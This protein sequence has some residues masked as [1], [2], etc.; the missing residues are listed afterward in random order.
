ME[1]EGEVHRAEEELAATEPQ[2]TFQEQ[3]APP[4]ENEQ[5]WRNDDGS[6]EVQ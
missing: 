2:A 4:H 6:G 5:W 3:T 1:R